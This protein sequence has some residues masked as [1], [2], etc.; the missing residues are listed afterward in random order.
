LTKG[1]FQL[2]VVHYA[3]FPECRD[4]DA[5]FWSSL[6]R[7]LADPVF[8]AIELH[9]FLPPSWLTRIRSGFEQGDKQLL[10]SA[11]PQLLKE[12]GLCALNPSSRSSTLE[13]CKRLIDLARDLSATGLMLISGKDPGPG[14]RDDARA[15]LEESLNE[16]CEYASVDAPTLTLSLEAFARSSPPSQLIGPSVEASRLLDRVSATNGNFRLTVD[17]SHL[18]QLGE[19]PVTAIEGLGSRARHIHLSTCVVIPGHPLFGDLHPSFHTPDVAVTLQTA[20][21]AL[22]AA[23]TASP[24][25]E[26]I[27]SVEV[28]PQ[29]KED[30]GQVF[31]QARS[32]LLSTV[33]IATELIS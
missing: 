27:V 24:A 2:G 30:S 1:R 7:L 31:E 8:D 20:G 6:E 17:L 19:D 13:L 16:L 18:A 12:H 32:D 22:A 14:D 33:R 5:I 28:R 10:L 25:D 29:G 3:S 26:M 9:T 11:G 15:A 21:Q 4:D 23:S